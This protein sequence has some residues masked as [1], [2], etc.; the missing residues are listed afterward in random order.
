VRT[1]FR[2]AAVV[3]QRLGRLTGVTGLVSVALA[4]VAGAAL[5]ATLPD[6]RAYEKVR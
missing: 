2:F 1:F 4:L 5:A 3:G 6:G